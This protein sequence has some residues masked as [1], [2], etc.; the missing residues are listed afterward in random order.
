MPVGEVRFPLYRLNLADGVI[1][2]VYAFEVILLG[3]D[4]QVRIVASQASEAGVHGYTEGL[5]ELYQDRGAAARAAARQ[6]RATADG[7]MRELSHEEGA[8]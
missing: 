1:E 8:P 7:L 6:L 4:I 3:A 2:T 5:D